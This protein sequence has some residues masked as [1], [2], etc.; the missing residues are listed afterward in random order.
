MSF[1]RW[2]NTSAVNRQERK[3]DLP[4]A[5]HVSI[6]TSPLRI[7]AADPLT[8]RNQCMRSKQDLG[9]PHVLLNICRIQPPIIDAITPRIL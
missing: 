6:G 3:V 1:K 8:A 7:H 9:N 4:C 2:R 5:G